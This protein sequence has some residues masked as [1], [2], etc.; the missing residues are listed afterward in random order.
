MKFPCCQSLR[1]GEKGGGK[2]KRLTS[3]GMTLVF[4]G[5]LVLFLAGCPER[6]A[7]GKTARLLIGGGRCAMG[8][9]ELRRNGMA[10]IK[11]T[12]DL[13]M[14]R[15]RNLTVTEDEKKAFRQQEREQQARIWANRYREGALSQEE[16][17]QGLSARKEDAGDLR[18]LLVQALIAQVVPGNDHGPL[19][20]LLE[21]LGMPVPSFQEEILASEAKM[22][23]KKTARMA[24]R[25]EELAALGIGGTAV[26]PNLAADEA[27]L[28]EWS[29]L[30]LELRERLG[31]L[32]S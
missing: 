25:R 17:L 27:W 13:M 22:A 14:E 2:G 1:S 24:A 5:G 16:L 7:L 10:E 19:L 8:G 31:K 29:R 21:G 11:S 15:I 28:R 23:R 4:L 18:F 32:Q 6:D 30:T 3:L 20:R 9:L 12:R 26:E